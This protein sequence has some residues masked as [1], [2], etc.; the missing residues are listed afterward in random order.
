MKSRTEFVEA[1]RHEI[2]GMV[3]DVASTRA[4]GGELAIRLRRDF[5]R[6]DQLLGR[7]WD[8]LTGA[9]N[10]KPIAGKVPARTGT[11]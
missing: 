6:I 2:G 10:D 11:A 7:M 3:A 9:A 4:T 1:Y 5:Q 8:E